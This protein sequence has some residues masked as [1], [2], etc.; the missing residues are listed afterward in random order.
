MEN[1]LSEMM[2]SARAMQEELALQKPKLVELG[3][4]AGGLV[5]AGTVEED[6]H[7]I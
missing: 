5:I 2:I 3:D 1:I 4:K 7:D 6:L